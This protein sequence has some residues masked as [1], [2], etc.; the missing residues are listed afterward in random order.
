MTALGLRLGTGADVDAENNRLCQA[1]GSG[2]LTDVQRSLGNGV[3]INAKTD[4]W[5]ALHFAVEGRHEGVVQLLLNNGADVNVYNSSI[6][7]EIVLD[8]ACDGDGNL[9]VESCEAGQ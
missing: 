5:T 4:G 9:I 2:R 8:F 1:A 6:S 7:L 3:D